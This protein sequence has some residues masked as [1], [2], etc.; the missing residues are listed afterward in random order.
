MEKY[1]SEISEDYLVKGLQPIRQFVLAHALYY[2]IDSGIQQQIY[3]TGP[4][5]I[6]DIAE[7]LKID[8]ER[9]YGFCNYL[10]NEGFV[11]LCGTSVE[12]TEKGK[13]VSDFWPWYK[14]LIGGYSQSFLQLPVVMMDGEK[15][16]DRDGVSVG[17]GSC[18]IS[19]YDALP[20]THSLLHKIQGKYSSIVDIGCGDG[21]FL[22]DL[23]KSISDVNCV[24]IDPN[25]ASIAIAKKMAIDYGLAD[26]VVMLAGQA[27]TIPETLPDDGPFCFLTAFVLQEILEQSGRETIVKMLDSVFNRY[28]DS[29]W[30]VIEVDHQFDNTEVMTNGL[31]LAY[32]NPYFLIHQITEQK[33][34]KR[35]FWEQL[36]KDAGLTILAVEHP[37]LSYDST[38]LK[39]GF[40]LKRQ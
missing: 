20:M 15:Y 14:L 12:L 25:L 27:P 4:K 30:I 5:E 11:N 31:G 13:S 28:P 10:M 24:G 19:Q 36:F 33:L 29:Y 2:F 3:Q 38:N 26:R 35:D 1:R 7:H 16:A 40:L 37:N 22:L 34:E 21:S 23:C 18:G 8:E 39:I 6:R 32:Y 9:L 17:I